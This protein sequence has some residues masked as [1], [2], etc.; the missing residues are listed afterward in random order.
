VSKAVDSLLAVYKHTGVATIL[1]WNLE[2]YPTESDL[3][4]GGIMAAL[5]DCLYRALVVDNFKYLLIVDIDEILMPLKTES[6]ADLLMESQEHNDRAHSFVFR[7]VFF[8]YAHLGNYQAI[9]SDA[10]N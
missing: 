2:G 8:F 3:H 10:S 5:N 1:P 6:L 9:S 4:Y 7:N